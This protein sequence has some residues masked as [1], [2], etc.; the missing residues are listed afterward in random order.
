MYKNNSRDN[1][2]SKFSEENIEDIIVL[3]N[4]KKEVSVCKKLNQN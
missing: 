4:N 2:N 3:Y 1:S